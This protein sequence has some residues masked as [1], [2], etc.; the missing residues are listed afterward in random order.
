MSPTPVPTERHSINDLQVIW[1]FGSLLCTHAYCTQLLLPLNLIVVWL[2]PYESSVLISSFT[3]CCSCKQIRVQCPKSPLALPN[4]TKQR[5]KAIWQQVFSSGKV[6]FKILEVPFAKLAFESL[7]PNVIAF[8]MFAHS[9][10]LPLRLNL[11]ENKKVPF[12]WKSTVWSISVRTLSSD[13]RLSLSR[14]QNRSHWARPHRCIS[15]PAP[16]QCCWNCNRS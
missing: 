5:H 12:S 14:S 1:S 3:T 10:I 8:L 13:L 9:A 4:Q 6:Y 2:I 16:R 11:Y 15:T 7:L